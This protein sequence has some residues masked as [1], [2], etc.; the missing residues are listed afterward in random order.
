VLI[1]H[2]KQS[3][4]NSGD[5]VFSI[6]K[7]GTIGWQQNG[8]N[9]LNMKASMLLE[10]H[11]DILSDNKIY[12]KGKIKK[13]EL[14][15]ATCI[16][17]CS[18]A[19]DA[20]YRLVSDFSPTNQ[21]TLSNTYASLVQ[22]MADNRISYLGKI[23]LKQLDKKYTVEFNTAVSRI[24]RQN[25]NFKYNQKESSFVYSVNTE[26]AYLHKKYSKKYNFFVRLFPDDKSTVIIY[27][28]TYY[29][30]I[31]PLI[32]NDVFGREEVETI[33][34]ELITKIESAVQG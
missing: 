16:Y 7:N 29:P 32:N 21:N 9:Q 2:E 22:S 18:F 28:L 10:I 13:I 8:Y 14:S 26:K 3:T 33:M 11:Y 19:E 4:I 30:V 20:F 23:A 15:K 6:C 12:I 25:D 34:T 27:N 31:D 17:E 24:Q 1:I 5:V